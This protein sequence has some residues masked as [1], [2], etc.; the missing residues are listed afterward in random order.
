MCSDLSQLTLS[1]LDHSTTAG[2]LMVVINTL[3]RFATIWACMNIMESITFALDNAH[4]VW[5][6]RGIQCRPLLSLLLEFDNGKYL[7][8][9]SRE[10][11]TADVA[12]FSLVSPFHYPVSDQTN[13]LS[14]H[15]NL[16]QNILIL[17]RKCFLRFYCSQA[18]RMTMRHLYWQTVFG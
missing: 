8:G 15:F 3:Q 2:V 13:K 16:S 1:L 10:R 17:F 9:V 11:I 14:R 7:N 18:T 12:A 4:Q 5:K 6:V